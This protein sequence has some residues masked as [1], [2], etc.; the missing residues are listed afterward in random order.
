VVLSCAIYFWWR[1][2]YYTVLQLLPSPSSGYEL[3]QILYIGWFWSIKELC[4]VHII[5]SLGTTAASRGCIVM[6][7]WYLVRLSLPHSTTTASITQYWLWM[8]PDF[9]YWLVLICQR[10]IYCPHHYEF[11]NYSGFA[12]LYCYV[13]LISGEVEP[14]T[15][16]YNCF[17]HPV[18]AMNPWQHGYICKKQL[19]IN[20]NQCMPVLP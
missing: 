4:I 11:R 13:Q 10:T 18:V 16:Y 15:L 14:T 12:W 2:P 7:N 6:C 3:S 17:H 20:L 1:W 5:L 9:V 8:F 19:Y